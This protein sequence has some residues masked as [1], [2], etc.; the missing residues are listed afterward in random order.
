MSSQQRRCI[1]RNLWQACDHATVA[2]ATRILGQSYNHHATVAEAT[3]IL[4]QAYHRHPTVAKAI[5]I[6]A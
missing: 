4:G 2:E 1:A 3:R 5:R 6:V